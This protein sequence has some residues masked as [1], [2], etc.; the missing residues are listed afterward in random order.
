MRKVGVMGE[1]EV[2]YRSGP[3]ADHGVEGASFTEV[4]SDTD[5]MRTV[6]SASII[7]L[8]FRNSPRYGGDCINRLA[9]GYLDY[10]RYFASVQLRLDLRMSLILTPI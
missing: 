3:R 7:E 1:A 4:N 8:S 5:L 9:K 10:K 2:L 6:V